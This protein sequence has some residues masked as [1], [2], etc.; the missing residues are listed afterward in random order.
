MDW[1]MPDAID[2]GHG[3]CVCCRGG[4][5][6]EAPA[7][8]GVSWEE[9]RW[10]RVPRT[11]EAVGLLAAAQMLPAIFFVFSRAG[12]LPPLNPGTVPA[13]CAVQCEQPVSRH[14]TQR[15]KRSLHVLRASA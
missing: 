15:H 5:A 2:E 8:V 9:P 13:A 10:K 14:G 3:T 4:G 7:G 12:A 11:E 6:E 1:E